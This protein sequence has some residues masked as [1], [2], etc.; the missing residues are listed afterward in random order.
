M[1]YVNNIKEMIWNCKGKR[2]VKDGEWKIRLNIW[3]CK[4]FYVVL[5]FDV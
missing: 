5:C 1:I 4:N 3:R 2:M